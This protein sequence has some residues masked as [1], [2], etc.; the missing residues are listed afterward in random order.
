MSRIIKT[1]LTCLAGLALSSAANAACM[2][3]NYCTSNPSVTYAPTAQFS[4]ISN[5]STAPTYQTAAVQ[6]YG[7]SGSPS[8]IPG[9]GHNESLRPTTC[10]TSVYNPDGRKVL[11]CYDVV[12]PVPQITYSQATYYRV[13]RPIVYVRYPVPVAVPSYG[14]GNCQ[15]TAAV[16]RY[17][18][19]H[20]AYKRHCR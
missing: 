12:K 17:N 18:K 14:Y 1:T 20:H 4:N 13:V 5:Y 3:S 2:N 10:P 7:F 16:S 11:G 15:S 19:T 9:L 8:S 6:T